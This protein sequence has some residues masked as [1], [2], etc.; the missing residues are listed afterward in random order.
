[1]KKLI[2]LVT[3]LLF[4]LG[5]AQIL[6][7]VKWTTSVEKISETK[8]HLISTAI[9]DQGWHLYSQNVPENGPI[10]TTFVYDDSEGGFK[11]I[12]NTEEEEGH[13]V[14]DPVFEMEIKFFEN[15]ATFKQKVE[16]EAGKSSISGFVEFMVCDDTRCL[17][18]TEVDL[19]FQLHKN[20]GNRLEAVEDEVI[21]GSTHVEENQ[22]EN[23]GLFA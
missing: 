20:S 21:D 5:N 17:P 22:E 1:M 16:V 19:T 4:T 23:K 11:I 18:P 6:D 7:P 10:P 9:V 13:I 2:L 12:G 3:L 14:D 8:Y 15:K